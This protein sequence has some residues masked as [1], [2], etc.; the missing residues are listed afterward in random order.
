[1]SSGGLND[2]RIKATFMGLLKKHILSPSA[3]LRI[4]FVE[5]AAGGFFQHSHH[6]PRCEAGIHPDGTR[7]IPD[8]G[9]RE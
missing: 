7:W 1:M 9:C 2:R 3:L 6:T 5:G 4:D 8:E